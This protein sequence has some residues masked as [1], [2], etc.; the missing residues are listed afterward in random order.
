VRQVATLLLFVSKS[1][2]SRCSRQAG[3][4]AILWAAHARHLRPARCIDRTTE[5][6]NDE[7]TTHA[8]RV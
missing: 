4:E 6:I 7:Q 2:A 1:N 8:H 3:F 5:Q